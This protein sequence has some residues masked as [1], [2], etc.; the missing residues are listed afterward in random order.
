[1]QRMTCFFHV[2]RQQVSF[3]GDIQD[4]PGHG[5][6]QPAPRDPALAG[7]LDQAIHRGPFQP[8]TFCDSVIL[9]L[10]ESRG[11]VQSGGEGREASLAHTDCWKHLFACLWNLGFFP[12]VWR[13]VKP[14]GEGR[15]QMWARSN[16]FSDLG[17]LCRFN[18][19]KLVP[20]GYSK[21][22][23]TLGF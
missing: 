10:S 15:R 6:V 20:S 9:W 4:P 22:R 21:S 18:I 16:L 23:K 19:C 2:S 5:P 17:G 12:M 3:S 13:S 7:G 1:M 11:K 8:R 14:Q